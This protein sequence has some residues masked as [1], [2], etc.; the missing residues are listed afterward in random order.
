MLPGEGADVFT[1][2]TAATVWIS[3]MVRVNATGPTFG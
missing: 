1:A 2:K 3:W